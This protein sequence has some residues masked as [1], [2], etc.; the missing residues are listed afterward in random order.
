MK[1][2]DLF[3]NIGISAAAFIVCLIVME[4]GLRLYEHYN[5]EFECDHNFFTTHTRVDDP[6]LAYG[7]KRASMSRYECADNIVNRQ[8][9][10]VPDMD[11]VY[12]KNVRF[13][14]LAIGDSVTYGLG[15]EYNETYPYYVGEKLGQKGYDVE[16]INLGV[17]GYNFRD[18][19][20]VLRS[21]VN[22]LD[23]DLVIIGFVHPDEYLDDPAAKVWFRNDDLCPLPYIGWQ[24]DCATV[25]GLNNF[26]TLIFFKTRLEHLKN[27][28]TSSSSS[29]DIFASIRLDEGR[30]DY[31]LFLDEVDNLSSLFPPGKVI[32][33]IFPYARGWDRYTLGKD[34]KKLAG[35]FLERGIESIDLYD[36]MHGRLG[37]NESDIRN[38]DDIVH[39]NARGYQY[40]ADAFVERILQE[41][42]ITNTG[43]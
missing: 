16:V 21:R 22:E 33:A 20:E 35:I 15:R 25:H 43:Q 17:S 26:R 41:K 13:R 31:P 36:Y 9:I 14:I 4:L 18:Y 12:G 28:E 8:G 39:L 30:G 2:R 29:G 23:P 38:G 6:I 19:V 11:E 37:V 24:T 34:D 10:R 40:A 27:Q 7:L 3:V 1:F 42:R 5:G 32:I